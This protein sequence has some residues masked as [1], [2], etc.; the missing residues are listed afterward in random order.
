[1]LD[2]FRDGVWLVELAPLID[3]ALV[4][5]AVASAIGARPSSGVET[6]EVVCQFLA[7]R[8][9]LL[10][11]DNCEHVVD[12]AAALVDRLLGASPRLRVLATSR[13]PLGV[14]GE[15]VWRVP[16]L[17]VDARPG[18][19]G[20]AVAL[21]AQRARQVRPAFELDDETGAFT[22][23]VCRRLDGIPLAIELAAAR[24]GVMSVE[25]I[26]ARLD[27]RFR[28]L[29]R[30][31]RTAVARQQTLQGAIDWSYGLLTADERDLFDHLGVFAGDFN[32]A[33]GTAVSGRDDFATLDLLEGLADK[34]MLEADP[35]RDRYR[36]LETLR[37][38]AWERLVAADRLTAARDAHA[39][40]FAALADVQGVLSRV[41]GRQVQALDRLEADYDNLR[42]ALAWLIEGR[43]TERAARMAR[44]LIG[45][46][47]IRHPRE[48]LGWF[49]QVI[50][51]SDE[52]PATSRSQLL[53]DAAFAAFNAGN[54]E[55]QGQ[56][57][58]VAIDV[59]GAGAPAIAYAQ[60]SNWH[61][62]N[63]DLDLAVES[64]RRGV[65]GLTT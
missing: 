12:G 46:F 16:S 36:L 21:F 17:S 64:A 41:P 49:Q 31:G 32:L 50:A 11:M 45:L 3:A 34:S 55:A 13:E 28:L 14:S 24:A 20:D 59:G 65:A 47:N 52:L 33:A 4:P 8:R 57:A 10:V 1:M 30:G 51:I 39:D 37:Q 56:Y 25:Q 60:L 43:H 62:A 23:Q 48:G 2:E 15:S 40:H 42:A 9:A 29:T 54:S 53:A 44:R 6:A 26:A 18:E 58:R 63:G 22:V 61:L 5:A 38:Y 19:V 7:Q 27:D 35:P